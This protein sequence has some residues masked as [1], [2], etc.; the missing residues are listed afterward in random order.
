MA[1][2]WTIDHEARLVDVTAA[3]SLTPADIKD[4]LDQIAAAGAMPYAKLF[5][6]SAVNSEF[7]V[8]ELAALGKSIRQYAIDGFGPLGPL[9]I[10]ASESH[11]HLQAALYAEFGR[12]QPGAADLSQQG[13]G[14]GL[15]ARP[16]EESLTALPASR[17]RIHYS[18]CPWSRIAFSAPTRCERIIR[19]PYSAFRP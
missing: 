18:L 15:A 7:S 9:A 8:Q 14:A 3:G 13:A 5:D 12:L 6:I 19:W 4:Y 17:G 10:V 16:S 1:L 11:T 2:T